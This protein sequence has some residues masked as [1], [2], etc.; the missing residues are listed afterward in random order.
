MTGARWQLDRE[1]DYFRI[2]DTRRNVAGYLDPDYG[3]IDSED[4]D[5]IINRM[6]ENHEAVH[7]AFLMLPMVKF[8]IFE[9]QNL[10][11]QSLQERMTSASTRVAA[12]RDFL[13]SL[14]SDHW[15]GVSHTDQDMLAVT[16]PVKFSRPT[17]LSETALL[18]EVVPMLDQLQRLRLL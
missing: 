9:S 14:D 12:W 5:L 1:E 4:Q 18:E 3:G 17:P 11:V 10:N 15:I 8:G 2:Y 6:L 7:G 13:D 16:L